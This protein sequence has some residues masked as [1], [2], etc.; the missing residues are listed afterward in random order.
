M[1]I[2]LLELGKK[3]MIYFDLLI[4]FSIYRKLFQGGCFYY[5]TYFD[6]E[7]NNNTKRYFTKP[8]DITLCAQ[9][10]S[11]GHDSDNRFFWFVLI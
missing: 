3:T 10:M 5:A 1:K 2:L 7:L 6:P 8:Y 4:V 9:R 11:Q